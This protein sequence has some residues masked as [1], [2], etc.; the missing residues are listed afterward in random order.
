MRL[1]SGEMAAESTGARYWVVL[2]SEKELKAAEAAMLRAEDAVKKAEK[3][4]AELKA[5]RDEAV[6]D[7]QR[8]RLRARE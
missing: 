1:P 8:A 3:E 2:P 5:R 7:Y 6:N 4:L